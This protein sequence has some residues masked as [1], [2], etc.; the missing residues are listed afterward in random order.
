VNLKN[1]IV[2]TAKPTK[3]DRVKGFL[4]GLSPYHPQ[5]LSVGTRL[6]AVLAN[7]LEFGN[8]VVGPE[9]LDRIGSRPPAAGA[10]LSAHLV[11][12]VD[13]QASLPGAEVEAVLTRPVFSAD[14]ELL[15]PVGSYMRGE[16]VDVDAARKWHHNGQLEFKFTTI[17]PRIPSASAALPP[18]E[19]EGRLVS[20]AING[21]MNNVRIDGEGEAHIADS[22]KRFIAPAYAVAKAGRG[23]DANGEAFDAALAGA[24]GSKFTKQFTGKDSGFGLVGSVTGAMVPPVGV[25]LGIFGGARAV[26]SNFLGPGKDVIL[27]AFT[28]IEVR[29]K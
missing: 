11:S 17:E 29:L 21:G 14:K 12:G 18:H 10:V 5:Y 13:S 25:G 24:Y 2:P 9:M 15:F 20:I 16:I 26:Y 19:I 27:P 7:P 8:A 23:F 4:W 28:S 1:A 6:E 22:A 3:G